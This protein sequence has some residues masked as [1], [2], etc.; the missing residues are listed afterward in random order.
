M[1]FPNVLTLL[2]IGLTFLIIYFLPREGASAKAWTIVIF[3]LAALTDYFDGFLARKH[4]LITSFGKIM[5]PIADKF[6]ILS[7]FYIFMQMGI[8]PVWGFVLIFVREAGLT[9]YR[10][11]F[12]G[13]GTVLS[14]EKFG[15]I[16]TVFQIVTI[17]FVLIYLFLIDLICVSKD[18][19]NCPVNSSL[20][21]LF[22]ASQ[23]LIYITILLTLLSGMSFFY[24]QKRS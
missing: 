8:F 6:L 15:K 4:G 23:G 20:N 16:K 18:V 22:M 9:V 10:L 5:D 21:L 7:V 13:K 1:T 19:L 12:V 2:R 3:A 11:F 24:N 14:A 17:S